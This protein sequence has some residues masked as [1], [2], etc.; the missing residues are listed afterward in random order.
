MFLVEWV[1][2][3]W[4]PRAA[5]VLLYLHSS[6]LGGIAIS[7]FWSLLNERFDPHS[8][9]PLM[10]RV[11]A[12]ATFGGFVGG[13]SAER[14]AALLPAG[15]ASPAAG[16][17]SVRV[18]VAGALAVGR[19]APASRAR[20]VDEPDRGGAMGAVS[21]PAAVAGPGLVIALAAMLAALADYL[22]KA[23]A[24]AYFGQGPQLVRFFGLFYAGTGL[25]AVLI[26]ALL[27]RL[28][29]GRLGLGGSVA[30]HPAVVAAASLLG[31]VLPSPWRGILPRGLDVVVRNSTFRAGYELLY[32]PL[33]EATK[34]SAKSIIDVALS[35]ALERA[36][37]RC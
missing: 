29:L 32:T 16:V 24:V 19:G 4:Q 5:A 6:V 22:L 21:A 2:L 12:A 14:V 20:V 9:K 26:Q 28:A 11:A 13:V 37:A 15:H 35:I 33:A 1:L 30:S 31:F 23:E 34:R 27:G 17:S 10:A 8:A 18:C 25:A 36:R 7:S 3:G